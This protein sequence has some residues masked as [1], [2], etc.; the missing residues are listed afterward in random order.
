MGVQ[1]PLVAPCDVSNFVS[2]PAQARRRTSFRVLSNGKTLGFD[3]RND[4]FDS[5][6]L[7]Y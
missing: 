3:P 4:G 6:T 5:F 7:N 2:V 1:F